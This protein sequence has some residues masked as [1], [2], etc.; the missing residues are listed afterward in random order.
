M[1]RKRTPEVSLRNSYPLSILLKR[2]MTPMTRNLKIGLMSRKLPTQKPRRFAL[3]QYFS[4]K[5][6][7]PSSSPT[8]GTRMLPTR[9]STRKQSNLKGGSIMKPLLSKTLV[10]TSN[11]HN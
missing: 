1:E 6:E 2:S 9:F 10:S 8:I 11:H 4:I 3:S 7:L 5:P